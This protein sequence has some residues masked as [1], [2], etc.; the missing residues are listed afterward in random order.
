[1]IPIQLT[2]I[3]AADDLRLEVYVFSDVRAVPAS[4]LHVQ[5][6]EAAVDWWTF[7]QNYPDVI[8]QAADEAG[9]QAFATDYFGRPTPGY[10]I[11][12][13]LEARLR[14]A[15]TGAEW[16]DT[17]LFQLGVAVNPEVAN[18]VAD[19]V[20]VP[21]NIDPIDFANCPS[22]FEG[23]TRGV[24]DASG[25]TDVFV[26][27]VI[28]PLIEAEDLFQ[29]SRLTRMTSSLSANEMTEDPLFTLNADMDDEDDFVDN[30]HR[31]DL[32]YECSGGKRRDRATRRL[33]LADGRVIYLPSEEWIAENQTSEFALI[34]KL[35]ATKAQ[36]IEETG[37]S[38]EPI[39]L[40]DATERLFDLVD[41][42]NAGLG[43]FIA[44]CAGCQAS[45]GAPGAA[46][47]LLALGLVGMRRRGR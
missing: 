19:A 39:V 14:A 28:E 8:T 13:Q 45:G 15:Q 26:E 3:A 41:E 37:R 24:F 31:A 29:R 6:N 25:P 33:E 5:I 38:G 1:S 9:G 35:G 47:L 2:S 12:R 11:D 40:F 4:Y 44:S 42:H 21:E 46:L 22:C 32:V 7:G 30:V 10:T 23:W 43:Q 18:I 27:F 34:E 36:I 20:D 16:V 17:A